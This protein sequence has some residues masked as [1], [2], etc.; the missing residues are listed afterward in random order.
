MFLL[1]TGASPLFAGFS[2]AD[3]TT[4]PIRI[5]KEGNKWGLVNERGKQVLPARYD[6]L[7][8]TRNNE[9]FIAYIRTNGRTNH[10]G[11]INTKGKE[12]IP[13]KYTEIRP[14]APNRYAVYDTN[15]KAALLDEMGLAKTAFEFDEITAFHGKLARFY[16]GGKAGVVDID[17][18]IRLAAEYQDVVI[19]NNQTVGAIPLRKWIITDG[20]NKILHTL[21]YDSIRPLG[22]DRWA[23]STRFYDSVGRPTTMAALTDATGGILVPYRPMQISDFVN[24]V[25]RVFEN[26]RFGLIDRQGNYVLPAEW[27]SMAVVQGVAV[28]GMRL[29][30]NWY[31]HLFSLKGKKQS[32]YTYQQIIPV[33]EGPLPAKREGRWGYIDPSGAEILLCRY[34]TTFAFVGDLARVRYN[35]HE[36]VINKEGL[37]QIRPIAE[38]I[39]LLTPTRFLARLKNGYQ[40]L[41]QQ[42]E[43]LFETS[44][45]LKPIVGGLAEITANRQWGLIDL[46]GKRLSFPVYD[47]ITDLQE[48]LAFIASR[49]GRRGILSPDGKRFIPAGPD[50][51]ERLYNL[52][53]GFI[54]AHIG[55]QQGF[56][57]TNGKL[58]IANRYDT[59]SFFSDGMAAVAIKGKWGYV[60]KLERLRV[61]PL[62]DL[63]EP[64]KNGYAVVQLGG[65]QGVVDKKGV[66]LL[67]LEYDKISRLSNGRFLLKQGEL[68]GLADDKGNKIISPKYND[69]QDL[70]NGYLLV[71]RN[72]KKGL[73]TVDGVGTIPLIYDI[74]IYDPKNNLY[75]STFKREG[76]QQIKLEQ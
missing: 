24:G 48:G 40:L 46:N 14:V 20:S 43:V 2:Q 76:I 70:Q 52:N 18:R 68:F 15:K 29:N 34:D 49:D 1:I 3:Q 26:N 75:L 9:Y 23:V 71:S 67:P 21:L 63:V 69:V 62:Y 38:H 54:G 56:V 74:L 55:R 28:A 11:L 27:D 65:R 61:Q 58:R 25:A 64:Y 44:E 42:G 39:T 16:K 60:D 53:E 17:G 47:Y 37:W 4:G 73:V 5:K 51:W 57:D 35:G 12:L 33:K 22:E 45:V 32:R 50:T 10:A 36:G 13:I 8:Y 31:W 72:G 41:N 59:V 66:F 6:S 19:Q 30:Q 7:Q